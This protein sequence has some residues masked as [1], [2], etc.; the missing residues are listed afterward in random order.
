LNGKLHRVD[1][2]AIDMYDDKQW[3]LNGIRYSF[4]EWFQQLT[5]EQQENYLWTADKWNLDE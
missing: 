3:C 5:P 4:E 2:P 1:G